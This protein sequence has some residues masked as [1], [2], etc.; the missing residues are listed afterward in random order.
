MLSLFRRAFVINSLF[1]SI[2]TQLLVLVMISVLP[3]LGIILYSGLTIQ[4]K[5]IARAESDVLRVVN[6][7]GDDHG[8][9]MDS[10]WQFLMTLSRL[11]DVQKQDAKACNRIF[12]ELLKRNP[13]YAN[14]F[15][16]T[17]AGMVFSNARP[18]TPHSIRDRKYYQ[19]VLKTMDFSVGEYVIGATLKQPVLHFAYPVRDAGGGFKGMV[20]VAFDLNR[21]GQIFPMEGL[22]PGS[23]L[24]FSDHKN[25][26][27]YRYPDPQNHIGRVD[28][29]DMIRNLSS[30]LNEGTFT[31]FGNDGIKC[32]YGYKKI[33]LKGETSP[34][35]FLRVGIPEE[36]A[37]DY[38]RSSLVVNLALLGGA[39]LIAMVLAWFL[40]SQLIV[41]RL[42]RLVNAAKGLGQ[43][44]LQVR[45]GLKHSQDELGLLTKAF[46]EMAGELERKEAQ[47]KSTEESLRKSEISSRTLIENSFDVIFT[48]NAD[49]SFLFISP[50]WERHFGYPVSEVMWKKFASFVHPDDVGPCMEYLIA[51]LETGQSGTSPEYRVKHADGSWR[52]FIANGSPYV[53][54]KGQRQFMGTGHD[55][56]ERKW[57]EEELHRM[58]MFLDSVVENIP[59]MIFLKDAEDLRFIRFN[60]AGEDLLGYSRNDLLGKNDCAFFPKEQADFFIQ[61]DRDVLRL[62]ETIDIPE[63]S[64]QT[65]NKG[66]RIL[67]TK[68]VPILNEK[69]ESAYLLGIS[70][71]ITGRKQEEDEKRIL[72]ERLQRAEKMEALGQ[73]AGGVAHDLNN[74][75]GV[76][77]GYSEMT[78]DQV[79]KSSPLRRG[80][81]NIMNGGLKAAA[82]VEDL[83]T[84]ARR[85][86]QSRS[87]LNLNKIV[88]DCQQ[89][90]E[91]ANLS[92]H[93]PSVKIKTNL[94]PDLL[95]ISGSSVHIGKTLYNL[96]SNASEAMPKG[97]TVTIKTTNQYLD[98]LLQGY[99][100]I[101]SGDYVVLS[102]SDTGEGI[103]ANDLKRIFEPFYTKK[104]MGRSGTGL[105][106]AVVWGTVKDHHGYINVQSEE[107]KGS[108]FTLYFPVSRE[109]V[110]TEAASVAISEYMGKGE[111]ILV[112]DDV[113]EQ[114]DLAAGMLRTL[115]YN[116]SSVSSGEEAVAYLK[117]H[118][119]DLMVLDMIMDPGMD[120]LD[121]YRRII[122]IPLKQKAIIVSG[123]S[124][125][126][127]VKDVRSLG[128]G[129]YVRKPYIKEKLGL[130]VRK[131]LDRK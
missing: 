45:T 121:T 98:T 53:D 12:G 52:W 37:L 99:D 116:V 48:L 96:I 44:D 11:P 108:T 87:I 74:V 122:E 82:I 55:I 34:H 120:G 79:D 67:H 14:I 61:K 89:S 70:E 38:A 29:P 7:M 101:Q 113:K 131:E 93:H 27:L 8:R 114:R 127:R 36:Q 65:R 75:L 47:R 16:A 72:E 130:A 4:Q 119:T 49:G 60:Q 123:F 43:G 26:V 23:R 50:A 92:G 66:K 115:N 97:G 103:S 71:D 76:I 88:S 24:N 59:H 63:E 41:Q 21:Y 78:L 84:L 128:A 10:T 129:A 118:Q 126:D 42:S 64:I 54:Q 40:G 77:V 17:A 5:D 22:P 125:S 69:G 2:R 111:S 3:A 91:F 15:S 56:T 25:S 112:V 30:Q 110:T 68:K 20:V 94:E 80:L 124:E 81:E 1:K 73:L 117:E 95:N 102:V 6:S 35:L 57:A 83:L 109:E 13:I 18:F 85:G 46:D 9:V 86:V 62:K 31:G 33:Y 28:N 100:Q 90:P 58:N 105:G 32:L 51:V 107:G 104:I 106:L 19:D 39:L